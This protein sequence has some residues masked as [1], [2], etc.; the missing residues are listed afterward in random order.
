MTRSK[1]LQKP[2]IYVLTFFFTLHLT[3]AIY[4]N[5]SFL[6][7]FLSENQV[8]YLYTFA[9]LLTV[10][11]FVAIRP[12][13]LHFG[14]YKTFLG[15]I[16]AEVI[17]LLI[18]ALSNDPILVLPAFI[19]SFILTSLAFFNLDIFLEDISND[20]D[21]GG[22]RGV[23]LTSL[24]T[25]FI[26]GPLIA[27][28]LLTNSDFW[29]VYLLSAILL[30]PVLFIL[31][32]YIKNFKDPH[33]K[34]PEFWKTA[35]LVHRN[36]DLYSIFI[37]GFL[38]RFFFAWMVI[39]TPIFLH[40]HIGFEYSQISIMIAI[41]LIA[42]ILLEAFLGY[43]ADK[44]I[45][46]KEILSTGF[47]ITALATATMSF[48]SIPNFWLWTAILF[49]TR[50]GASMIEVMTETYLFKKVDSTD[51]NIVS[52]FRI[53]RPFA[54]IIAP[55]VASILLYYIEFK[56]LYLVLGSLMLYGLRYSLTIR[57]TR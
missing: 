39:Y 36:H 49:V 42:F 4:I 43:L 9:S 22:I 29:K 54:Y 2:I 38:L 33:Y 19:A 1:K 18:M 16:I 10:F 35:K 48:I 17:S 24:N 11:A 50:I 31:L 12:V 34:R 32:R 28:L 46:E 30:I 37:S 7:K 45:G 20:K 56:F 53:V 13:L 57:D 26:I 52:F 47:I 27:G 15:I 5:S 41:A 14:N 25:A 3:P 40:E 44:W 51:I 8:G 55:L 6:G 23:F 21:T